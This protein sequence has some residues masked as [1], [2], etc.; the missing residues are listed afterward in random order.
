MKSEVRPKANSRKYGYGIISSVEKTS[1]PEMQISAISLR[2]RIDIL[3]VQVNDLTLDEAAHQILE[4]VRQHRATPQTP[5]RQVVT[6]NPEYVMA[7]RRDPAFLE[8]INAADMVTPDGV[9]IIAAGKLLRQPFQARVT[10]VALAEKLF[11][12]SAQEIT[13]L[14]GGLRLFL[15]GAGPE[16][17]QQA[18]Q[19][20]R[21]QYPGI[22]IAGTFAGEAGPEGDA[23]TS[24]RV[25]EV[26]ADVV[27]VAY[28]M[29][30]QDWWIFRNKESNKDSYNERTSSRESCQAAV[31]I[32]IGGVLDYKA[33]IVALA[34]P[35]IRR[36]GLEWAYR[37]Y[38]EPRRWR[39]QLALPQF[40]GAVV[41][42]RL[43]R[44]MAS[45]K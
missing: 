5:L 13:G 1:T 19:K 45:F 43:R 24:R 6:A 37:L 35:V 22:R 32:G 7:A 33:G 42:T 39:R 26:A 36:M 15:L 20:L 29:L 18:A 9:G 38:K 4:W 44:F 11:Q 8:L 28:G 27:L 17:A 3:G 2:R 31:A 10:G 23:E 41:A 14:E 30:K 34:P 21:Q 40:V 16:V 12:L 25:R